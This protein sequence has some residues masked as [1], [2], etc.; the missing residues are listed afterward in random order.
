VSALPLRSA[1]HGHPSLS[2]KSAPADHRP[3]S[4]RPW[5]SGQP[6]RLH[7]SCRKTCARGGVDP[8]RADGSIG[9]FRPIHLAAVQKSEVSPRSDILER[10]SGAFAEVAPCRSSR[11]SRSEDAVIRALRRKCDRCGPFHVR[12]T[13]CSD[14]MAVPEEDESDRLHQCHCRLPW[15][16]RASIEVDDEGSKSAELQSVR[17]NG[18]LVTVDRRAL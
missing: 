16:W 2:S 5:L 17:G 1:L 15:F 11:Q 9:R 13:T 3:T 8:D 7:E 10:L 4:G 6:L 18:V 14:I 12:C